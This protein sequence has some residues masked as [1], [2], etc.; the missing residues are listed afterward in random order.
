MLYFFHEQAIVACFS[1]RG[2]RTCYK[3]VSMK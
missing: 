2:K 3:M 1:L